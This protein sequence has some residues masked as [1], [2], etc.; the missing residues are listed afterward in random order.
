MQQLVV[1]LR[2]SATRTLPTPADPPACVLALPS[3]LLA[4]AMG[5]QAGGAAAGACGMVGAV[6]V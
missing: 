6:R 5:M 1:M 2:Q 4:G 3:S